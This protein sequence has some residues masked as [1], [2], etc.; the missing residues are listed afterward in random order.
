MA[1]VHAQEAIQPH[2]DQ[3]YSA[4]GS[5]INDELDVETAALIANLTL[6]NLSDLMGSRK[7]KARIHSLLSNDEIAY[8]LQCAVRSM[9][10]LRGRR[11][12]CCWMPTLLLRKRRRRTGWRL[13]EALPV[14]KKNCQT[15]LELPDSNLQA[16]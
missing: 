2:H 14:P 11:Q 13:S 8:L 6:D 3:P 4:S 15:R 9:A 5:T 7:G 10:F 1:F 16:I 12:T